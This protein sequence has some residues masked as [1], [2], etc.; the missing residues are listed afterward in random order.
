[1][2]YRILGRSDLS[3]PVVSYGAWAIGGW[4]WGGTDDA[5][6]IRSI[7]AAIDT[8]MNL[9][10]TAPTYGMGHSERIVGQA[11]KGRRDQVI[12]ATKCGVRWDLESGR[13]VFQ[14]KDN[15]GVPR[16]IIRCLRPE[17]IR[18]EI[19]Q[20]LQRL[21]V[22]VIDLYQCHWPDVDTPLADTMETLL[23]IQKQGK[24]RH[25]GVS[26]F[27]V[28]MMEECLKSGVIVSD[29]PQYNPLQRA[30]EK[31]VLP[32]CVANDIGVLAYSPIAQGLMTGKVTM[33]RTFKDGDARAERPWFQ[34]QNR[35]RVLDMLEAIRPIADGHGVT[36]SQLTIN[37]VFSQ[38][39]LTTAIVG[40]RDEKQVAENAK[41]AEFTLSEDELKTIREAVEA[42]GEPV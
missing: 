41:A 42:L 7:Q 12:V 39:G 20:S 36:L 11:I 26:N 3:V 15:D 30:I 29:Q 40:A 28:E 17:S 21:G 37:W 23:D 1:M 18:H 13:V 22:D 9:V 5:A 34:P 14:T 19:E 24:I 2:Q 27:T 6:A 38:K 4:M 16:N 32:F 25:I 33:D 8:G 31:D 10:D 35:K